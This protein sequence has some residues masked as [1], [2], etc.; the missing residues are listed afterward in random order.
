M[1]LVAA[2][3]V[4]VLATGCASPRYLAKV[5]HETITGKELKQE[6]ARHHV[7]LEGA[8]ADDKDIRKYVN[9]LVDRR[10]FVQEGYRVGLQDAADVRA[11]VAR[12]RPQKLIELFRRSTTA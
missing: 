6:F 11:D 2:A 8:L 1:R 7:A 3:A 9:R 10:L 5:N 12:A 4:A